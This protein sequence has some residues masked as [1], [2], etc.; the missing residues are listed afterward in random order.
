MLQLHDLLLLV[1][2]T[3]ADLCLSLLSYEMN[4]CDDQ[5]R[6]NIALHYM[7]K[8]NWT[9][10]PNRANALRISSNNTENDGLLVESFT[11]V[12]DEINLKVKVWDRDFAWRLAGNIPDKCPSANNWVAM[13][14]KA[15]HLVD[16]KG[17]NK[18]W[19]KIHLFSVWDD[20]C[21]G[22]KT[23]LSKS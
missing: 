3:A 17:S 16:A 1:G 15:D 5:V 2:N 8:M 12:S 18:V 10:N 13:P 20:L 9:P 23:N 22:I 6:Y 11:G 14:T 7:L 19:R 21:H 4:N